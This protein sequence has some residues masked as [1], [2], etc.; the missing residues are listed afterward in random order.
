MLWKMILRW[1]LICFVFLSVVS[2][3]FL[4][5]DEFDELQLEKKY[6][7]SI[8]ALFK[9]EE[10]YLKEWIEYHKL[11]GVEHFYLYDNGSRD[12]SFEV[13]VPYIK[14]GSVT[15]IDW[16]DFC[17]MKDP[18]KPACWVLST[19]LTAYEN[20][21][22]YVALG[23]TQWL[24]FIDVDEY[25]VPVNTKTL[26]EVLERYDEHPGLQLT[27]DYFDASH[28]DVLPR[29]ELLIAT[30]E[31][32]GAPEK[33]IQRSVEKM[34]FKPELHTSVSW[35]PFKCNFKDNKVAPK[36]SKAEVRINKYV[37]RYKGSLQFHKLK[38]RLHVDNRLLTEKEAGDLLEIG[39][40]IEDQERAIIRFAPELKRRM[41]LQI[42]RN[43]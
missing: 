7:V 9:N 18:E 35:P 23:D 37:N 8:C 34:I 33:N 11:I 30:T 28:I 24:A 26:T 12:R 1:K 27:S 42:S 3:L 16:P 6:S 43:G 15:L 39:Y 32:T 25:L 14:E 13:L 36:A 20:A 2:S 21:A 29:R 5:A 31:L 19:Q 4:Q 38:D 41:G 17:P 10:R 40:E 22:K